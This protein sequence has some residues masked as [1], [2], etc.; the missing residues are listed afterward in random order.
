MIPAPNKD[1]PSSRDPGVPSSRGEDAPV[2]GGE[3]VPAA[4]GDGLPTDSGEVE[5]DEKGQLTALLEAVRQRTL[6]LVCHLSEA[7]L[8][9]CHSP[10]MSPLVWDL[11][12]IAAHEDLWLCHR[13][14][15]L[16]LLRPELAETYDAFE[17]PRAL[18]GGMRL[19]PPEETFQ[20]MAEV[21]E[22]A[23]KVADSA[24][25]G[26]GFLHRLVARHE[27]QH[28]E[29]MLQTMALA[30]LLPETPSMPSVSDHDDRWVEIDGGAF[31]IGAQPHAFSYDNERPRHQVQLKAFRISAV[32]VSVQEWR[33]F[34]EEGGC[35]CRSL[36][37]QRGWEWLEAGG[38]RQR[39]LGT[40]A[41]RADTPKCNISFF[42]AE[43]YAKARNARLPTEQEWE[44]ACTLAAD[45][46]SCIGS[47]WEWT[48]SIFTGYPGFVA[49]PYEEYSEVFFDRGWVVLRGGSWA[50][51]PLLRTATFRNWDLPERSQIFAGLRLASDG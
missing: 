2:A 22:R 13:H 37:S 8:R 33:E 17:T 16:G 21:R 14:A 41:E 24:G 31:S 40:S 4:R 15:G 7:D 23:L 12:H 27:L 10:I 6:R 11:A 42:E 39:A 18:R 9:A 25:V 50:T 1:V 29:T 44:V 48:S 34:E 38:R 43:A 35:E 5:L 47:V 49:F 51:H 46:L 3:G 36:W 45:G 28:T 30:D 19:L 26:D 32:P 20:Y